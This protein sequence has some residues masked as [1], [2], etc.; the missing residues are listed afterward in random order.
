MKKIA[1]ILAIITYL[2]LAAPAVQAQ[3]KPEAWAEPSMTIMGKLV[4]IKGTLFPPNANL[5]I[6][7][8]GKTTAVVSSSGGNFE[9][10]IK[11]PISSGRKAVEIQASG[12]NIAQTSFY[13]ESPR[14]SVYPREE[15]IGS[16]VRI[17]GESLPVFSDFSINF[18]GSLMRASTDADGWFAVNAIVP[19]STAPGQKEVR[20]MGAIEAISSFE[21]LRPSLRISPSQIK[22]G[23]KLTLYI[24]GA[25]PSSAVQIFIDGQE[26][27]Q[28]QRAEPNGTLKVE[29]TVPS[30]AAGYHYISAFRGAMATDTQIFTMLPEPPGKIENVLSPIRGKVIRV[31]GYN[32]GNGKWLLYDPN[33]PKELNNLYEFEKG[34]GYFINAAEDCEFASRTQ[35]YKLYKGWNMIGWNE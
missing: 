4:K 9:T 33:I 34:K 6:L 30:L 24:E 1:V 19:V 15:R 13:V 14:L 31:W 17:S 2:V 12:A 22:P 20:I 21:I 26:S 3:L 7:F 29:I 5:T 18:A 35:F 25:I 10:W 28:T 27:G 8:E 32:N 11:S 23:N 16:M